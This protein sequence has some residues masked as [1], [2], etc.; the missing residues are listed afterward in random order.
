MQRL[1]RRHS[2]LDDRVKL[3]ARELDLDAKQQSELKKV[4]E[5]QREQVVRAWADGSVP[6]GVRVQAT[7]KISERTSDQIRALLNDEQ[8][9]RYIQPRSRETEQSLASGDVESWMAGKAPNGLPTA[10]Q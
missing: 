3:L 8:R 10:H 9:K 5:N 4:L 6:A 2:G 1:Q 7:Q